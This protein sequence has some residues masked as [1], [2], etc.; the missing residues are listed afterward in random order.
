MEKHSPVFKSYYISATQPFPRKEEEEE[1]NKAVAGGAAAEVIFLPP[2]SVFSF[3]AIITIIFYTC[4]KVV[5]FLSL[6]NGWHLFDNI[7]TNDDQAAVEV[8]CLAY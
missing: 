7:V 3:F 8:F 4:D 6:L 2:L 1:L 5:T